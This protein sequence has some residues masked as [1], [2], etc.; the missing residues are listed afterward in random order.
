VVI[1]KT[2]AQLARADL[3]EGLVDLALHRCG[4]A[5]HARSLGEIAR[6]ALGRGYRDEKKEPGTRINADEERITRIEPR[7][8]DSRSSALIRVIRIIRGKQ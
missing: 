2:G 3:D 7:N 6:G 8:F 5:V 1:G 4:D